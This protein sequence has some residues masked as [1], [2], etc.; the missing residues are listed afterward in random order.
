MDKINWKEYFREEINVIE[1]WNS[2]QEYFVL[3]RSWNLFT[4]HENLLKNV[5]I[6]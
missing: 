3:F 1:I 5:N 2:C 4:F 6:Y